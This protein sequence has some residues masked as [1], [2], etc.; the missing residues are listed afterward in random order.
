MVLW[1]PA[2][3]GKLYQRHTLTVG[4]CRGKNTDEISGPP[5]STKYP[6][7]NTDLPAAGRHVGHPAKLMRRGKGAG[8]GHFV[9]AGGGAGGG[10]KVGVANRRAAGGRGAF[11]GNPRGAG[12][13]LAG[14]GSPLY[15]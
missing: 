12:L 7:C 15:W 5:A 14:H 13:R 1:V 11:A 9:P 10:G 6:T 2:S 3:L 8:E 4:R